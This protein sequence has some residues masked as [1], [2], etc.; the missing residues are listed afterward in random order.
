[1]SKKRKADSDRPESGSAASKRRKSYTT[2][3]FEL[4][5]LYEKIS[6]H[7]GESRANAVKELSARCIKALRERSDGQQP[8]LVDLSVPK[9]LYVRLIR[10]CCSGSKSTNDGFSVAL[11]ACLWESRTNSELQDHVLG[12]IEKHT[13]PGLDAT[14]PVSEL[15][16]R[17]LAIRRS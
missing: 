17:L 11:T 16:C 13:T 9:N 6:N 12:L 4:A 2:S 8:A 10:G 7:V 5:Q 3:D 15:H 1:M 14:R